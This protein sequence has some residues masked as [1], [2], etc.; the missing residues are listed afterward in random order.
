MGIGKSVQAL[1][2]IAM[3]HD[4]YNQEMSFKGPK[5]VVRSLIVCPSTLVGHWAGEIEKYFPP[6]SVF[7]YLCL[8]GS[9]SE[10]LHRWRLK[11]DVI[12]IVIT[13]YSS[14]RS[15]IELLES[16]D[17][18]Y[19]VLDEGHLMKNP[20]TGTTERC[21]QKISKQFFKLCF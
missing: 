6:K 11:S 1:V 8:S 3:A 7:N 9:K 21:M 5:L 19:C 14:L 15:D 12:N 10:R 2:A 20:K 18:C 17:W 4:R 13:S 16:E